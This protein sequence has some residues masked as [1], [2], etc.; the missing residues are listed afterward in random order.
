M[1]AKRRNN[2]KCP[3]CNVDGVCPICGDPIPGATEFSDWLRE[4]PI[5]DSINFGYVTTNI[6]YMWRNYN[7]N[8]WML[9]EEKR[10]IAIV[11]QWQRD[12]LKILNT[13]CKTDNNYHGIHLIQFEN[14]NPDDGRIYL[15]K[16]EI[17]RDELIDFLQFKS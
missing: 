15:D 13:A 6:D 5:I 2:A 12:M 17:T 4:Q 10:R 7:T 8:Q 1:T 14:K 9:I 3:R 11:P 16:E